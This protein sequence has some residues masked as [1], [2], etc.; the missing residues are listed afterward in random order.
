MK[1]AARA[2]GLIAQACTL[3]ARPTVLLPALF[4]VEVAEAIE[5]A[6]ISYRCYDLTPDLA[7]CVPFDE[8][9]AVL[10][11]HPFGLLRRFRARPVP[12]DVL[13]IEDACH[14]LRGYRPE[15]G[16]SGDVV[17][18]SPRKELGWEDGG[19]AT[20]PLAERLSGDD[21][22]D[23]LE[24][25]WRATHFGDAVRG[26]AC[27]TQR[28]REVLGTYLPRLDDGDLLYVL[29]LLSPERDALT[30]RLR[31]SGWEAWYW[32]GVLAGVGPK[33]TPGAWWLRDR[34]CLVPLPRSAGHD[35]DRLLAAVR[36]ERLERWP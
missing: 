4:C 2:T 11:L 30:N 16:V 15:E 27:V 22:S 12:E 23:V 20:G 24:R 36:D 10:T 1:F 13:W 32:R 6:K 29:P 35:L 9:G 25:R 14:V 18:Y 21:R 33:T 19:I 8:A 7:P 28:A 34:L 31:A 5:M 26:G 3:A 17:I